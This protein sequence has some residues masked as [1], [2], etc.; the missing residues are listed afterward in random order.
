MYFTKKKVWADVRGECLVFLI[1]FSR[2]YVLRCRRDRGTIG[3]AEASGLSFDQVIGK[4]DEQLPAHHART[5]VENGDARS[6][7]ATSLG[8]RVRAAVGIIA[9]IE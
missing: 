1:P 7:I 9:Q 8:Q 4:C 6:E 2:K 3:V 5:A